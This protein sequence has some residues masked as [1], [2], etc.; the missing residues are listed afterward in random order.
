MIIGGTKSGMGMGI[1]GTGIGG[2]SGPVGVSSKDVNR[3]N[4]RIT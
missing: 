4:S 3:K 2:N 1:G